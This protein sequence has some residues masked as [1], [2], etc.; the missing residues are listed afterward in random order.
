VRG[1]SASQPARFTDKEK[2]YDRSA[3]LD[4]LIGSRVARLRGRNAR[5]VDAAAVIGCVVDI[6]LLSR[7][8]GFKVDSARLRSLSAR[9]VLHRAEGGSVRF[10][11][12]I[13][14]DAIYDRVDLQE[15]QRLHLEVARA[16]MAQDEE[17]PEP[18][19]A[20][21]AFECPPLRGW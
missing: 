2:T 8:A 16:L 21:S 19:M 12:R 3:W 1:D 14:R 18:A 10:K 20:A 7:V 5:L 15:R 17:H 9:D 4:A 13:T 11:H 6:A